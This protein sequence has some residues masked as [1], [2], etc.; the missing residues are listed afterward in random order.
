MAKKATAQQSAPAI[1][2]GT[3]VATAIS[4]ETYVSNIGKQLMNRRHALQI[5]L[6]VGL[7][8]F[9]AHGG[10]VKEARDMLVKVYASAGYRCEDPREKDYKTINR[11]VNATA[12][13]FDK[14][15]IEK[16]IKAIGNSKEQK[17]INGIAKHLED[18][19]LHTVNDV[20]A[21][22]GKPTTVREHKRATPSQRR[23][24][25]DEERANMKHVDVGA[26]HWVIPPETRRRDLIEA[27]RKL[28][29]LAEEFNNGEVVRVEQPA[30]V[31]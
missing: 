21:Y 30:A 22:A 13:L 3:T 19:K 14:I 18:Y 16:I 11:R 5:E 4:L 7:A 2:Q 28:L 12:G 24:W 1:S 26:I 20:L 31:H 8:I 15:G 9:A 23:R 10:T 6:S 27:A 17:A 29:E 25:T